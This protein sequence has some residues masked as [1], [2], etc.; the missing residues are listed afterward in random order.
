MPSDPLPLSPEAERLPEEWWKDDCS[1]PGCSLWQ[2]WT[3]GYCDHCHGHVLSEQEARTLARAEVIAE[4]RAEVEAMT[5]WPRVSWFAYDAHLQDGTPANP[6][7]DRV[8]IDRAYVL[9]ALSR[10]G[11]RE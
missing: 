7:E 11:E 9:A 5:T 1:C 3:D 2:Q 10:L 8:V 4:L 6:T